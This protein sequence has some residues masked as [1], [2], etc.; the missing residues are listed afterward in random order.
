MITTYQKALILNN[1]DA[2]IAFFADICE[3]STLRHDRLALNAGKALSRRG[4][5]RLMQ[6]HFPNADRPTFRALHHI[7]RSCLPHLEDLVRQRSPAEIIYR[8]DAATREQR[9]AS[10]SAILATHRRSRRKRT[11]EQLAVEAAQARARRRAKKLYIDQNQLDA[12]VV[13][14]GYE[15]M[16]DGSQRAWK[17]S[18]QPRFKGDPELHAQWLAEEQ[19]QNEDWLRRQ[20]LAPSMFDPIYDEVAPLYPSK[21]EDEGEP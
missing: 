16:P 8:V 11:P 10:A 6:H 18:S 1:F 4:S 3:L 20:A 9:A 2:L 12:P 17:D 15:Q 19:K 5:Q 21:A 13:F 7:L 14:Q